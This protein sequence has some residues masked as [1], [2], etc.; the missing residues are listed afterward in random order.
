MEGFFAEKELH[1]PILK[2]F[3]CL[4][5]GIVVAF[6][7]MYHHIKMYCFYLKQQIAKIKVAQ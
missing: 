5:Y 3:F 2:Y 7:P 6:K 1:L 4:W